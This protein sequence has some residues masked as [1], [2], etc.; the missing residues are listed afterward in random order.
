MPAS[1]ARPGR[2]DAA[3]RVPWIPALVV[4]VLIG[5]GCQTFQPQPI[6]SAR[7]EERL[8]TTERGGLRVSVTVP[9]RDEARRIF[10]VEL[11]GEQIQP[12][13]VRIENRTEDPYWLMLHGLDPKHFSAREAAY[14]SHTLLCPRTNRRTDDHFERLAIIPAVPPQGETSGFAFT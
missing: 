9:S 8:E 11:Y 12:V 5:A 4:C 14:E 13:W 10:G 7:F 6:G 2:T 1:R 3:P